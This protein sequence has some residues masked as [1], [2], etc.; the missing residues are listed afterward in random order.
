MAS[1]LS[2][3]KKEETTMSSKI[4]DRTD[5]T[6]DVSDLVLGRGDGRSDS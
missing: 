1:Q 4:G 5:L 2:V 3:E 6:D